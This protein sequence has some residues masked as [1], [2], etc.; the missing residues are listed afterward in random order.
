MINEDDQAY[1]SHDSDYGEVSFLSKT[2]TDLLAFSV[3][4]NI[5]AYIAHR[6]KALLDHCIVMVLSHDPGEGQMQLK[7]IAGIDKKYQ[8]VLKILG[9]N[10]VGMKFSISEEGKNLLKKQKLLKGPESL[11][12]LSEYSLS[13]LI[14]EAIERIIQLQD[15][16]VM[17]ILQNGDFLGEVIILLK[18]GG[19]IKNIKLLETFINQA[20]IALQKQ[21]T[22]QSLIKSEK[23]FRSIYENS[24]LGIY[25]T[26]PS[27]DIIMANP[28]MYQLFGYDSLEEFKQVNVIDTYVN[29]KERQ[30]FVEEIEKN[31]FIRGFENKGI[32]KNGTELFF[33]ESAHVIR[34]E[35]GK[36]LYYDGIIED[37]TEKIEM[38]QELRRAKEKAEETDKLKSAF[39][40]NMSHEIRTP[41][42]GIIGFIQLLNKETLS[43]ERKTEYI[44]IIN[45]SGKQLL[46][47]IDDIIDTAKIESNQLKI[48]PVEFDLNKTL[49]E[50]KTFYSSKTKIIHNNGNKIIIDNDLTKEFIIYSDP[51][52]INQ[53]L[54]NLINNAIK[55][56]QDGTIHIGYTKQQDGTIAFYVKDTGIGIPK[57]ELDAIFERFV[58]ID[59]KVPN[60]GG[61][62][63]G[64]AITKGL[65]ELLGG[66]INVQSVEGKGTTFYFRIPV[67][68]H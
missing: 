44:D 18:E 51:V 31:G 24:T 14:A 34:D 48:N 35:D 15:I 32:T 63:L 26:S 67:R 25:R 4:D 28:A 11:Q 10:P 21:K 39:L 29:K 62:G 64:L 3:K 65:V 42:N 16:Y 49:E 13:G 45:S 1:E 5:Y 66:E 52:R 9:R 55:F 43:D 2:A 12:K 7:S 61:T 57:D 20:S 46:Q 27:G 56:T 68:L 17:G 54:D 41:M 33:R 40:A 36:T 38:E 50:I 58:Q 60:K 23:R 53:I 8:S 30:K 47:L 6:L 37:Y 59:K 22:E 19:K